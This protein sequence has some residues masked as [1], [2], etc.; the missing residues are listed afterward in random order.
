MFRIKFCRELILKLLYQVDLLKLEDQ[1]IHQILD[2]N[3]IFMKG[4]RDEE[5]EFVTQIIE[6][7]LQQREEIDELIKANLIGWRISRLTPIDRCLIRM[8]IGESKMND[9]KA[10]IIDDHIRIAKKYSDKDS[11]KIIN[12]ILDKVIE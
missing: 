11:Y 9:Q 6:I 12:A 4:L 5:R 1:Q 3:S 8:G 7:I 10:V 2:N